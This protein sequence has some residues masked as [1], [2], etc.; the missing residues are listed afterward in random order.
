M[1]IFTQGNQPDVKSYIGDFIIVLGK[2]GSGK[3]NTLTVVAEELLK[4]NVNMSVLDLEDEFGNLV[5]G[6]AI[7]SPDADVNKLAKDSVL[8]NKPLRLNLSDMH[9]GDMQSFLARYL[10]ALWDVEKEERVPHCI[11]IDELWSF[12]PQS[13]KKNELAQIFQKIA[14]RGRKYGLFVLAASQRSA[15]ISKDVITQAGIYF[16]TKVTHPADLKVYKEII[17]DRKI[18]SDV[19]KLSIGECIY[20]EG[21]KKLKRKVKLAKTELGG[22]TPG[23]DKLKPLGESHTKKKKEVK[24]QFPL[25]IVIGIVFAAITIFSFFIINYYGIIVAILLFIIFFNLILPKRRN[26]K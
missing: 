25:V 6:K 12:A 5:K 26:K 11:L 22:K 3:S 9:E 17:G 14:L 15:N 21:D 23:V 19:P 10:N 8:R 13:G 2:R 16:L 18:V 4:N 7:T 1:E 24:T 20:I